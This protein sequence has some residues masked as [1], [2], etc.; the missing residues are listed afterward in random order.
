[1]YMYLYPYNCIVVSRRPF[2]WVLLLLLLLLRLLLMLLLVLSIRLLSL[3]V[4]VVAVFVVV[5]DLAVVSINIMFYICI[6]IVF[7][8]A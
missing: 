7:L 2:K 4:A 5:D 1:M 6:M 3:R 8:H